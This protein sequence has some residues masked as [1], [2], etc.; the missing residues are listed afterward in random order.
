MRATPMP[1]VGRASSAVV[2]PSLP[3]RVRHDRVARDRIPGDALRVEGMRAGD[4]H[5]RIHLIGVQHGPLERLHAPERTAGHGG[6]PR[7][8]K[9]VE[10]RAL[11]ADHVG[12][13][14]DRKIG[15]VGPVR[16]RVR[17]RRARVPRQP[18]RRFEL[19]TKNRLVS[20][21]LPGPIMPSH[22]PRPRPA[23]RVAILGA[24]AVSRALRRRR[25]REAG[26][27]RISTQRMADENYVVARRRQ[28]AVR[29]V[30]DR[31]PDT[32]FCPQSSA[33][34]PRKVQKLRF[35]RTD[36]AGGGL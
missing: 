23:V 10:Q 7:N 27:V 11:R 6:E 1:A 12:D 36:R 2:V 33:K 26:R 22:Q 14:D 28:P 18:P 35:N 31:G 19:T 20:N 30:G 29:L 3:V 32:M 34:R 9:L 21:A 13:R 17:G 24:E 4:G 16:G 15:S 25:L 5:N 8:A